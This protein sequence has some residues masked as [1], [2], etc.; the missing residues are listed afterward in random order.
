MWSNQADFFHQLT[1]RAPAIE[2]NTAILLDSEVLPL[3]RGLG[4]TLNAVYE[5]APGDG[6]QLAYWYFPMQSK[7][8]T[9]PSA[10]AVNLRDGRYATYFEGNSRDF[11]A[12]SFRTDGSQCLWMVNTDQA[13][14]APRADLFA[15]ISLQNGFNRVSADA[16]NKTG[17]L[18]KLFGHQEPLSWCY[19]FEKADLARQFGDWETVKSLWEQAEVRGIKPLHGLEY[20]P[21]I[22]A[23]ARLGDMEKAVVLNRQA[24]RASPEME[25]AL[26]PFWQRI[27]QDVLHSNGTDYSLQEVVKLLRCKK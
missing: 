22:E 18:E 6:G 16:G 12:F 8:F 7:D 19:T 2:R 25:T 15:P 9:A 23:Y 3:M 21:F 5:Q 14:Y 10:E 20:L 17:I 1:W 24:N 11:V 26:C 13:K 27:D 4:F